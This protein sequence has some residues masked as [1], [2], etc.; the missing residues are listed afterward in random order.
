MNLIIQAVG[1][2]LVMVACARGIFEPSNAAGLAALAGFG[3]LLLGF[4][5]TWVER[6]RR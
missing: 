3:L 5:F 2:A 1:L 4:W 6:Q